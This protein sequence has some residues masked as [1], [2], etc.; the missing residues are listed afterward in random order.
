[1]TEADLNTDGARGLDGSRVIVLGGSSGIGFAVARRARTEGAEVVVASSNAQ[2]VRDAVDRLGGNAE[3]RRLDLTDERAVEAFFGDI[4]HFDHLVF[5]AGDGL[6]LSKIADSDLAA[7]RRAFEVRYW[8]AVAAAK[9]SAPAIREGGSIVLTSGIS[10][11]RP[12]SGWALGASVCGAV[13]ALARAFAVE[14]A[15]FASTSYR[16]ALCAPICG[17]T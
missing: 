8:A 12:R 10:A 4:G 7:A 6:L 11:W 9:Y 13:E 2:R 14:I 17:R 15:R 16:P 1:M 5:T 3:G